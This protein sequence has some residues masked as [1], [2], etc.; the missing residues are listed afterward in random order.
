MD[1]NLQF[2][3]NADIDLNNKNNSHTLSF[4]MIED[5]SNKNT[6][7][8][9]EVGC[10]AGYFGG[11]LKARGHQVWGVEPNQSSAEYAAGILDFVYVGFIDSFL[12]QFPDE[13]FDVIVFGDVLEHIP[14]P[15]H[16]LLRIR[17]YLNIGGIVVASVPNV[18]HLG[19][20]AML[21]EGRWDY[22]DLG[23]LD[24]THLRFFTRE[25]LIYMF[26]NCS[27]ALKD[28][29]KT[30][31]TVSQLDGLVPLNLNQS[32][33]SEISKLSASSCANDFQY[34]LMAT[35]TESSAEAFH[36]NLEF[37]SNIKPKVIC[38]YNDFKSSL[39]EIRIKNLY[40][41]W[42]VKTGGRVSFVKI[43]SFN[44]EHLSA[45]IF[46]FQREFSEFSLGVMSL[47][48][49]AGKKVVFD[50]D[51]LLIE[52]P[53]FLS[54]H[55]MIVD[56]KQRIIKAL[57]I[58]DL[59]TSS[60][61]NLKDR[62]INYNDK[63]ACVPNYSDSL[64]DFF[65]RHFDVSSEEVNLVISSSDD[66]LVDLLIEPLKFIQDKYNCKIIAIGPPGNRLSSS[67]L[68]VEKLGNMTH[69]E[70]KKFLAGTNNAIG[71]IP[72]DDSLFSSC[73]SPI[74]YFDYVN[75][76]LPTVCSN[77]DPYRSVVIDG[78]TGFL[79]K[80]DWITAISRLIN[81]Y[82]IRSEVANNSLKNIKEKYSSNASVT[83]LTDQIYKLKSTNSTNK[84][85]PNSNI[86]FDQVQLRIFRFVD[87]FKIAALILKSE[88]LRALI[89]KI[90]TK[91]KKMSRK[92]N[93]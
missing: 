11:A 46:V 18:A 53:Q 4:L 78:K 27:Y 8:I 31:L 51:D 26:S 16:V 84:F 47:I 29:K 59:I 68:V 49:R 89:V 67:G 43:S 41:K 71:L 75:A 58:A 80:D 42:A 10:S 21:A 90:S 7:K 86:L 93:S 63:I 74:K 45:D 73:K 54:H 34:V 13:K 25:S 33:L 2:K 30:E 82:S 6:L 77:V 28:I 69:F 61:D 62:L 40:E 91:V 19:I 35:P 50:I 44:S 17:S 85:V 12:D 83:K 57:K 14:Y 22:S 48:K 55:K 81:N 60:T 56:S 88:G 37:N 87:Y 9:L 36:K 24:E 66:V 38:F 5:F 52:L 3:Y 39:F 76:G 65:S 92:L 1:K 20:R 72:L 32:V 79:V 70:F 15:D 23:I 64:P